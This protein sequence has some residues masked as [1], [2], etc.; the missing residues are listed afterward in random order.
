MNPIK[1][2]KCSRHLRHR[3]GSRAANYVQRSVISSSKQSPKYV[4]CLERSTLREHYDRMIAI[5]TPS[6]QPRARLEDAKFAINLS[7]TLLDR[8]RILSEMPHPNELAGP[9]YVLEIGRPAALYWLGRFTP[10]AAYRR[11]P[12]R[13]LRNQPSYRASSLVTFT[14]SSAKSRTA[15]HSSQRNVRMTHLRSFDWPAGSRRILNE[16]LCGCLQ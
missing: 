10:H 8:H 6:L 7:M 13:V 14:W 12:A 5:W 2:R 9:R 11:L 3:A 16:S 4:A 1:M 15:P